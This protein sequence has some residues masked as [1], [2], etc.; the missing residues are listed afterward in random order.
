MDIR[1]PTRRSLVALTGAG[2]GALLAPRRARARPRAPGPDRL[3]L[4]GVRGGPL[5][6][7]YA[8]TP[9]A[10][11][12]VFR[13]APLVVDAGYGVT[14]KLIEAGIPLPAL[15]RVFITHHHSDHNLEL[16]PLLYNAW[17]DGLA[18]PLDVYGPRG[19]AELL[20]AYWLSN[21]ID[22]EARI[23]DEGRPDLRKLVRCHEFTQGEVMREG[24][25]AVSALR[26]HHPPLAESYALKFQLGGKT[27]VFSGDTSY[28]PALADFARGADYLVHE[29]MFPAA[30]ERLAA[31]RPNASRLAASILSHHTSAEDA[32]RIAAAAGVKTLVLNHFVPGDDAAVT[33][34]QWAAAAGA[35]FA[36]QIVVGRP[37]LSLPL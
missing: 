31:R 32:G 23:G 22:L 33:P 26:N 16:G 13:G 21:R 24:E 9:S 12:I 11:V 7:G 8:Q 27:V 29:A 3:V 5:V 37:M 4:L 14:L 2:V 30:V 35:H 36:G 17:A 15:R 28:L 10:S 25:L 18:D 1:K 34:A 20:A 6:D 19:L